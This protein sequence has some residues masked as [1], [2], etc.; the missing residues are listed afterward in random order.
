MSKAVHPFIALVWLF[1]VAATALADG[2]FLDQRYDSTNR[3]LTL[4]VPP[5]PAAY[6][7]LEWT[8]DF[9]TFSTVG[10]SLGVPGPVWATT[11]PTGDGHGF[12]RVREHSL[13]SPIDSDGDGIDDRYELE[14]SN[15]LDPLVYVDASRPCLVSGLSNYQVYLR[16]LFGG[17]GTALQFF[18]RETSL[19][20]LGAPTAAQEPISMEVSVYNAMLGSGPPSSDIPQVYSREVSSW[21][22]GSPSAPIEANSRE[23]TLWN[24]GSPSAPTEA[25]SKEVSVYS[26]FVGSGPPTTEYNQATSREFTLFNLGQPT[27]EIE[28]ISREVSLINFEEPSG[29]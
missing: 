11:V 19:F 18:S 29:P 21:N 22:F 13:F 6:F 7:T 1:A 24:F 2:L 17:P 16:D 4:S 9:Q 15:C 5:N 27:S 23:A 3:V 26:A 25:T 10:M 14:H 28:A 8:D 20:N 12:L